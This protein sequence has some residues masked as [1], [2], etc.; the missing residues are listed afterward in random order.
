[1]TPH[2]ATVDQSARSFRST[3]LILN[4]SL[5]PI[6]QVS[7]GHEF[8][9]LKQRKNIQRHRL[10][11]LSSMRVEFES[12]N[13]SAHACSMSQTDFADLQL[14]SGEALGEKGELEPCIDGKAR[15]RKSASAL[16]TEVIARP[17]MQCCV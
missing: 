13:A 4:V 7:E 8:R 16:G 11:A 6:T 15:E 2:A 1:M 10:A 5:S 12:V 14:G 3:V 9:S 17:V